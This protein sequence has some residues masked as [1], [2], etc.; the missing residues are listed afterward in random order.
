MV[1]SSLTVCQSSQTQTHSK[2]TLLHFE[3]FYF[4]IL[5]LATPEE[6]GLI[7]SLQSVAITE[8]KV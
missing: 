3:G 8:N 5:P 1:T 2:S 4:L 6:I 7:S